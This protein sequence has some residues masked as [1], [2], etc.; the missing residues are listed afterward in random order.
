MTAKRSKY[1]KIYEIYRTLR[2]QILIFLIF[3]VLFSKSLVE[4]VVIDE[5][6]LDR[7][8]ID[9]ILNLENLSRTVFVN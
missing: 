9:S 1:A 4:K 5:E 2:S 8:D 3:L 7:I 6:E